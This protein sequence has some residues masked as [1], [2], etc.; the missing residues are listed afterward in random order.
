MQLTPSQLATI[1]AALRN[2]LMDAE[3]VRDRT[4]EGNPDTVKRWLGQ[5][6]QFDG[7]DLPT[8]EDMEALCEKL[9]TAS[10]IEVA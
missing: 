1:L 4:D 9:N 2:F 10:A 7:V 5:W 8:I 3:S 6:V